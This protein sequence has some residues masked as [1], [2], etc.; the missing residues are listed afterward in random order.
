MKIITAKIELSH[1]E[2]LDV[3]TNAIESNGIQY[4]ACEYGKINI[5]RD[6]ELNIF[7]ATFRADNE[8]GVKVLYTVT[9]EVIQEGVDAIFTDGFEGGA[10][11]RTDILEDNHDAWTDDTIIQAAL[12]G[13]I[14]YG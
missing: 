9:P 10:Q 1:Q 13:K 12:F 6:E 2:R 5:W 3:L 4:W 14:I 11:T 7:K 8:Q